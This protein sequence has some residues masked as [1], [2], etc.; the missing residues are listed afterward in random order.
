MLSERDQELRNYYREYPEHYYLEL[1]EFIVNK[2]NLS[3]RL[4]EELPSKNMRTRDI[5]NNWMIRQDFNYEQI[6]W[7]GW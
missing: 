3:S 1:P 2:L 7:I 4:L 6:L 5:I